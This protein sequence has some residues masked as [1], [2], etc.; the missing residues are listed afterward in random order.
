MA[1]AFFR[2]ET[3]REALD[4][5][6][7]A[8]VVEGLERRARWKKKIPRKLLCKGGARWVVFELR[9]TGEMQ[10][11]NDRG[12]HVMASTCLFHA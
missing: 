10:A 1:I 3:R 7:P 12:R 6:E 5:R 11:V 4:A 8:F 2:A 9:G